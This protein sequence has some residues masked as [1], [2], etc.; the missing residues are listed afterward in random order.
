M[1]FLMGAYRP[2][3]CKAIRSL[4]LQSGSVI[5]R[6]LSRGA[7]RNVGIDVL[8]IP[9]DCGKRGKRLYCFPRFPSGRHFH[10]WPRGAFLDVV[11]AIDLARSLLVAD[12]LA[13]RLHF[14]LA[15]YFLLRLDDRQRVA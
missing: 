4:F 7:V 1:T 15:L 9:K 8:A 3:C 12:L 10:R 11:G 14:R 6:R 2:C 5:I 13:V